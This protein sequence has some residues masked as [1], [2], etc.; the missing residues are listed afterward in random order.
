VDFTA[1]LN[2]NSLLQA[3]DATAVTKKTAQAAAVAIT[4]VILAVHCDRS[5]RTYA[6]RR[7]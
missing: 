7:I 6:G 4:S 2:D 1:A 3:A 5:G